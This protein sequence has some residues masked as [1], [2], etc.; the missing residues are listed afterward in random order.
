LSVSKELEKNLRAFYRKN[1]HFTEFQGDND[2][3][4][5]IAEQGQESVSGFEDF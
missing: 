3:P 1:R 2:D 4:H 5:M